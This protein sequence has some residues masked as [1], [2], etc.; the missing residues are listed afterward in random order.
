MPR[1]DELAAGAAPARGGGGELLRVDRMM[2]AAHTR[3]FGSRSKV[4]QSFRS[5]SFL[6]KK[7]RP[8]WLLDE[9][10]F[11]SE[12]FQLTLDRKVIACSQSVTIFTPFFGQGGH[13]VLSTWR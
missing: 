8:R 13:S 5:V 3:A 7:R 2:L 9:E 10:N 4:E 11:S 1:T 6:E 12:G